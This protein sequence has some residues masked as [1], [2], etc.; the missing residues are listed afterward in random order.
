MAVLGAFIWEH[1]P[2]LDWL[3]PQLTRSPRGHRLGV[4][5]A[6]P[7]PRDQ[8]AADPQQR[9]RILDHDP[10]RRQRPGGDQ[11]ES[12]EAFGPRLCARL[13]DLG[14]MDPALPNGAGD[15]RAFPRR[16]LDERNSC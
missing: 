16:A 5:I 2:D 3:H 7:T 10:E 15:E 9:R 13:Y 1:V 12:L 6:P 11:I 14:I 4:A 8:R